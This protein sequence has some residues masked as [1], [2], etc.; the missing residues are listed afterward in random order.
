[1]NAA[2]QILLKQLKHLEEQEKALKQKVSTLNTE[3][4]ELGQ[5]QAGLTESMQELKQ[6][7]NLLSASSKEAPSAVKKKGK[8]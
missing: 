2:A 1:M 8:K 6:A 5:E 7:L 3:L 4:L